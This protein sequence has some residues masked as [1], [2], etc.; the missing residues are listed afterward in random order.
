MLIVEDPDAVTKK[1]WV[2][3]LVFNIPK[4]TTKVLENSIPEGGTEGYANGGTLGYEGPCPPSGN[5]RYFF[6][7]YALD[8]KLNIPKT[9]NRET[10]LKEI[11]NHVIDKAELVGLYQKQEK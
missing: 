10:I 3:W 5:H 1:P 9:S 7:L 2:H 4:T 8:T 6:K 11:K